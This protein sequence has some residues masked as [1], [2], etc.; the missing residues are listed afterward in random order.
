MQIGVLTTREGGSGER[1]ASQHAHVAVP[2]HRSASS[3]NRLTASH[4]GS[5]GGL[6]QA[7][8]VQKLCAQEK[9]T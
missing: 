5:N 7:L 3:A 9:S 1:P 2:T 6:G 8:S 4:V